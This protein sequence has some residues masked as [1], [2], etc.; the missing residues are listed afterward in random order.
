MPSTSFIP[1]AAFTRA[2]LGWES[3]TFID[4]DWTRG[5][6]LMGQ[7]FTETTPAIDA[8]RDMHLSGWTL[9]GAHVI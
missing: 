6:D 8:L 5:S 3:F 1:S 9:V 2:L 4:L 7:T